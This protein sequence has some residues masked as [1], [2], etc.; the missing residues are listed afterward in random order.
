MSITSPSDKDFEK[1]LHLAT[2]NIY[3][4]IV[5]GGVGNLLTI[6]SVCYGRFR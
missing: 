6:A 3:L 2:I 1:S 5:I 4:V